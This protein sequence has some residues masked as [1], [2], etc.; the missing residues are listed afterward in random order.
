MLLEVNAK[1]AADTKMK[2]TEVQKLVTLQQNTANIRNVCILAH[3][4]HGERRISCYA[5]YAYVI[6][7]ALT[8]FV[9]FVQYAGKNAGSTLKRHHFVAASLLLPLIT[10][11]T[12]SEMT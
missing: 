3:V 6:S 12:I 7:F 1:I 8:A 5:S 4:D 2:R 9:H 10:D 11:D